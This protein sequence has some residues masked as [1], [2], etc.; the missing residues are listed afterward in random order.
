MASAIALAHRGKNT[1]RLLRN[2]PQSPP[3]PFGAQLFGKDPK[4]MGEA[5]RIISYEGLSDL[6]DINFA[7]PAKK[8]MKSGHGAALLRDP[9]L[10]IKI[11]ETV[12]KCSKVPVTV[13]LRPGLYPPHPGTNPIILTL[14]PSLA[15]AGAKAIILHGRYASQGFC[16]EAD[17]H[18]VAEL[19]SK[20]PIPVIGSGDI[21]TKEGA[22]YRLKS[23]GCAAVMLGRA[24]R[25]RPWL[26]TQAMDL[27]EGRDP[28]TPTK[29]LIFDIASLHARL[30][31]EEIGPRALFLLRQ[32]L[33][34]YIRDLPGAADY[35]RRL[36]QA[37]DFT[38]QRAILE[39]ALGGP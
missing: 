32:V 33:V 28:F 4:T 23:S 3:I 39:E 19:S 16:G 22:I 20:L 14:A 7:C 8:V 27:L 9:N 5:A 29:E 25:G 35:R 17:W 15:D 13:K 38:Q 37:P 34:W 12:C 10:A 26:F 1:L 6:I 36:T 21:V 31:E 11:V 24:T 30:L 2:I 18:L